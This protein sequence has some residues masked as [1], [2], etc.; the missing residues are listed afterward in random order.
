MCSWDVLTRENQDRRIADVV[1]S[2]QL[3]LKRKMDIGFEG[4][5]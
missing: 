5:K 2:L 4:V 1:G 3:I